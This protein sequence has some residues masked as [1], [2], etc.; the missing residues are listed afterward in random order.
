MSDP[1]SPRTRAD[2]DSFSLS[3]ELSPRGVYLVK[4]GLPH[5]QQR[6]QVA[7]FSLPVSLHQSVST[8]ALYAD[9]A[10]NSDLRETRRRRRITR[11]LRHRGEERTTDF[12]GRE[13]SPLERKH[14]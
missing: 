1:T 4:Q 10:A 8:P 2:G 14:D 3:E 9:S 12:R 7:V 11:K 13:R 6:H 5:S